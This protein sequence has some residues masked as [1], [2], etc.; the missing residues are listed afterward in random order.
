M[1]LTEKSGWRLGG[2][3]SRPCYGLLAVMRQTDWTTT[4]LAKFMKSTVNSP[5]KPSLPGSYRAKKY[6]DS[7]F[8][9]LRETLGNPP[10]TVFLAVKPPTKS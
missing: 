7:S 2:D 3:G 6:R 9:E 1:G 8:S 5:A 4:Q 10:K